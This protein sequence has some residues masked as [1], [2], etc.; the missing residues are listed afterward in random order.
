[1]YLQSFVHLPERLFS[2]IEK[3]KD[4]AFRKLAFVFVVIHLEDLLECGHID[5]VAEVRKTDGACF[6]LVAVSAPLFR[7]H[8]CTHAKDYHWG[9]STD[10]LYLL[11]IRLVSPYCLDLARQCITM[12]VSVVRL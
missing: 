5:A 8:A 12:A 9:S 10:V 4:N 1:M 6:G 3:S 2:L 11:Q 7:L